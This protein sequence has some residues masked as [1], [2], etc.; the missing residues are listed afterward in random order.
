MP[1][2]PAPLHPVAGTILALLLALSAWWEAATT[3]ALAQVC[4]TP[5]AGD[6]TATAASAEPTSDPDDSCPVDPS[7]G[8]LGA[9]LPPPD[10]PSTNPQGYSFDLRASLNI[11]FSGVPKQASIYELRR[12]PLDRSAVEDLAASL[13]VSGEVEDRGDDTFAASGNGQL[14]ASIDLVQYLSPDQG[15]SGTLPDDDEA[16]AAA[17]DWLRRSGLGPA[18]LGDG[19]IAGRAEATGRIV[20]AFGPAEPERVLAAY[21]SITVSLGPDGV[22]LEAS[23]RW[24]TIRRTDLYQ[25]RAAER[26]WSEVRDGRAYIEADLDQA[27]LAQGATVEGRARYDRIELAYTSAGP[28]GGEQYLL[29]IFVFSGELTLAEGDETVPVR[30]YVVALA[31][32]GAP[33]GRLPSGTL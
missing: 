19:R 9:E 2:Q 26:A 23:S 25:L 14:F 3:A 4:P 30:A 5:A 18:D 28:P 7:S 16:I 17:R 11:G 10:L 20:V 21:P 15:G 22:V 13:G 32:S 8:E 31:N 29:P 6:P 33:V 27:G 24:A 12:T 1:R